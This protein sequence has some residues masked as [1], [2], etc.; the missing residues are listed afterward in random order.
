MVHRCVN[1]GMA[2]PK[3]L[4]KRTSCKECEWLTATSSYSS[5]INHSVDIKD[6]LSLGCSQAVSEHVG[7]RPFLLSA[8]LLC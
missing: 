7:A 6:T 4:F 8:R 3:S 2:Q 1:H 5:G